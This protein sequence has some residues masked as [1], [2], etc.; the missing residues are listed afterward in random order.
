MP[1]RQHASPKLAVHHLG[2]VALTLV[3]GCID[4]DA[5]LAACDAGQGAC[6]ADGGATGG[7]AGGGLG[8]GSGGAQGGGTGGGAVSSC[9]GTELDGFCWLNPTPHGEDHLCLDGTSEDDLW[10]ASGAGHFEH[11]TAAG[12]QRFQDRSLLRTD[13]N[14]QRVRAFVRSKGALLAFGEYMKPALFDGG[15]WQP[16]GGPT[17]PSIETIQGAVV[18]PD[19]TAV[20]A[21]Y[22]GR[23]FT[24]D[25]TT[26]T[27]L[28]RVPDVDFYAPGTLLSDGGVVFAA[29]LKDGGL[30]LQL[31]GPTL[32]PVR[33]SFTRPGP[34]TAVWTG[35]DGR[36]WYAA[37]DCTIGWVDPA[38][39]GTDAGTPCGGNFPHILRARWQPE[40][41]AF[42]L[43]GTDDN[44]FEAS[45]AQLDDGAGTLT[46]LYAGSSPKTAVAFH[47]FLVF[48]DGGG[49]AVGEGGVV[50]RRTS[51]GWTD[52]TTQQRTNLYAV[53]P[54]DGGVLIAGGDSTLQLAGPRT[55]AADIAVPTSANA[56]FLG[57]W[58]DGASTFVVSEHQRIARVDLSQSPPVVTDESTPSLSGDLLTIAGPDVNGLWAAGQL[59]AV[60][61]R[62]GAGAWEAHRHVES[63]VAEVA[64]ASSTI[65]G[66]VVHLGAVLSSQSN[67]TGALYKTLPDAGLEKLRSFPNGVLSLAVSPQGTLWIAGQTNL[68]WKGFPD[69]GFADVTPAPPH[70]VDFVSVIPLTDDDVWAVS[71][72]G[73]VMHRTSSGW[74]V[75][76]SGARRWLNGA[77]VS[78][79]PGE[80]PVLWLVG[81]RGTL[82]RKPL[83]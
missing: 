53:T 25:G 69:G 14:W 76:E 9:P 51:F 20:I 33:Q 5:K 83:P 7:G 34:I 8:G 38:T 68:V 46:S 36:V 44:L 75:V 49:V 79:A 59:G 12:R 47:D 78:Q 6:A 61:K 26:I 16:L 23:W 27:P 21:G 54:F 29:T 74:R 1:L 24:V 73:L 52:E 30:A 17:I 31:P 10:L 40:L 45:P 72:D 71:S 81:E 66:G 70:G 60:W 11:W 80:R 4:F 64:F 37:P 42:V 82:L 67:N 22:D 39:L 63:G 3:A 65:F 57:V 50:A 2:W 48:P 32:V 58:T 18:R 55:T 77:T 28:T 41:G 62:T 43:A 13:G 15:A 35:P 19:G 56:N